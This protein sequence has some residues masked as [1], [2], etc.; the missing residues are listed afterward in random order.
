MDRERSQKRRAAFTLVE[1]LVV[2]AVIAV[3][4]AVLLPVLAQARARARTIACV[5][6]QRQLA[7]A[8][9]LYAQDYDE[10][11]PDFRSDPFSAANADDPPYWHDHFCCGLFPSPG[12]IT[13]IGLL[14]P[15]IRSSQIAFCP[16]DGKPAMDGRLVTSYEYKLWL[17]RGRSLA[18]VA[19]PSSLALLWE[20]WA[21][22]HAD[23]H[24]SEYDR[25]SAMNIAFVDG[26]VKWRRLADSTAAR[27]G[28]GP[29]LHELFKENEP[30][31]S[32]HG[33]D[34]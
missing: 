2:M 5:S 30:D 13:F 16:A 4:A 14:Q 26:H 24:G 22:H 9:G 33:Q 23:G 29:N 21:Y 1:A 17:A 7:T 25:D 10:R 19:Y 6:N 31:H 18:E 8:F 27:F 28:M 11:Y 32:A 15:H 34:F 20:Q 12:Q 3:L